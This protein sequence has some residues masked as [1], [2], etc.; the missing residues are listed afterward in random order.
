MAEPSSTATMAL[1]ATIGLASILP[2]ID[3]NALIGA[4]AGAT[5]FVLTS[6]ELGLITR[7]LYLFISLLMGYMLVPSVLAHTPIQEPALAG[8]IG[9]LFCITLGIKGKQYI[10][11]ANL[12]NILRGKSK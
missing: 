8:F 10:E 12:I 4:F 3:G 6:K 1:T 5:L 9:G 2:G 7:F 11:T